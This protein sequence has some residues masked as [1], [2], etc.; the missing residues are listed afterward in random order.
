MTSQIRFNQTYCI[1]IAVAYQ[2]LKHMEIIRPY[3]LRP[4]KAS[5]ARGLYPGRFIQKVV[6]H[7]YSKSAS[8]STM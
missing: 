5:L 1:E 8:S 4:I 6:N 3:R 2:K 7:T